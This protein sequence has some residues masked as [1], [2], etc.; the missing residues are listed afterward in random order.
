MVGRSSR[1][2]RSGRE[3]LLEVQ[4]WSGDPFCGQVV[5]GRHHRGSEVVGRPSQRSGSGQETIPEIQKRSG[6]PPRSPEVVG[7][8]FRRS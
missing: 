6:D 8:P 2:S 4:K 1:R 7:R 5:V 3:T